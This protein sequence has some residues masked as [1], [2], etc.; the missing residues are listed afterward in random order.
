MSMVTKKIFIVIA[1][2]IIGI[3]VGL[4][5]AIIAF[6]QIFFT[7]PFNV[8]RNSFRKLDFAEALELANKSDDIWDRH[9]KKMQKDQDLN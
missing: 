8:C 5:V 1:C 6:L 9:I 3:P 4:I 2:I 7:F